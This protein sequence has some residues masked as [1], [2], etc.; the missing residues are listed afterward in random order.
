MHWRGLLEQAGEAR[1]DQRF[2]EA[3]QLSDRAAQACEEARYH[4]AL[5]RGDVMLELGNAAAA[6]SSYEAVADLDVPDPVVD[7]ARGIALFELTRL[8]EADNALRS[9]IRGQPEL[10][11][12]YYALGLVAE[13]AGTGEEV[14]LF[15]W[16]RRLDAARFP[17]V[18]QL[19]RKDFEALVGEAVAALPGEVAETMAEVPIMI[20]EIPHPEDLRSVEPP[21][22][23]TSLGM[24]VDGPEA[25]N[26]RPGLVLFKR[27]IERALRGR[28]ARVAG[29]SRAIAEEV[30]HAY[31]LRLVKS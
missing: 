28:D 20:A 15:R 27:N 29:L 13:L 18:E 8:P 6:L 5:L 12:A 1:R 24:L 9:A 7:C 16:A 10:A 2:R 17:P 31:G 11:E 21:I 14:E 26:E 22:S 30:S 23:P 25:A 3:L 4:A 19:S